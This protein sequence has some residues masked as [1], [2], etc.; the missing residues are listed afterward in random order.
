MNDT[1]DGDWDGLLKQIINVMSFVC[2]TIE[3]I[4]HHSGICKRVPKYHYGATFM[5]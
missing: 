2:T 1:Y 4:V 3:Y 5:H